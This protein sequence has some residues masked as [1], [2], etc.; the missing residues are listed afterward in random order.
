MNY[1]E[2]SLK[3]IISSFKNNKIAKW[4][5]A[6][7]ILDILDHQRHN[8]NA[9]ISNIVSSLYEL[10]WNAQQLFQHLIVFYRDKMGNTYP[11]FYYLIHYSHYLVHF[12]S[13]NNAND[14]TFIDLNH[15]FDSLRE[16]RFVNSSQT[17]VHILTR[18]FE[19]HEY[20]ITHITSNVA[21]IADRYVNE[22]NKILKEM[23]EYI[24]AGE[25][26]RQFLL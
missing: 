3:W 1:I 8:V 7:R 12:Y 22:E 25:V 26:D 13:W 14:A 10:K 24:F 9:E 15:S 2:P 23:V 19:Y 4:E 16:N 5:F 21:P 6:I 17:V 18:V 20:M 11:F